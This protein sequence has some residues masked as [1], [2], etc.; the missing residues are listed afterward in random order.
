MDFT[1]NYMRP[2]DMNIICVTHNSTLACIPILYQPFMV[3]CSY[4]RSLNFQKLHS[5]LAII[6]PV[7]CQGSRGAKSLGIAS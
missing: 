1:I 7:T 4:K 2:T 3:L 5:K 6:V